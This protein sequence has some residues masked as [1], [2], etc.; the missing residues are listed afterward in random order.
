MKNSYRNEDTKAF[1]K[2]WGFAKLGKTKIILST[3]KG[4]SRENF[5]YVTSTNE[6]LALSKIQSLLVSYDFPYIPSSIPIN[7]PFDYYKNTNLILI[8][9]PRRNRITGEILEKA[10]NSLT[11]GFDKQS[12]LVKKMEIKNSK[13][14]IKD[15]TQTNYAIITKVPNPFNQKKVVLIIAGYRSLYT[16]FATDFFTKPR[17]IEGIADSLDTKCFEIIIEIKTKIKNNITDP[18]IYIV[19][20]ENFKLKPLEIPYNRE[21]VYDKPIVNLFA[22]EIVPEKKMYLLLIFLVPALFLNSLSYFISQGFSSIYLLP[23]F[24][25]LAI[26][27][28]LPLRIWEKYRVITI[29]PIFALFGF[30]SSIIGFLTALGG[31]IIKLLLKI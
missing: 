23:I 28:Y 4:E 25:S 2:I 6:S 10:G 12:R 24:G 31:I 29:N 16:L 13:L 17:I 18:C 20:P 1:N 27:F 30:C 21:A 22:T 11:Y 3:L 9:G 19:Y 7:K 8:G 15:K 26:L 5:G 14:K